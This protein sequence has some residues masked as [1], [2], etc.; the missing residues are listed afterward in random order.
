MEQ[1][2]QRS[3][4]QGRSLAEKIQT[5]LEILED[6]RDYNN[7]VVLLPGSLAAANQY[8]ANNLAVNYR[9]TNRATIVVAAAAQVEAAE[10][11]RAAVGGDDAQL[12]EQRAHA[13]YQASAARVETANNGALIANGQIAGANQQVTDHLAKCAALAARLAAR[14]IDVPGTPPFYLIPPLR[15]QTEVDAERKNN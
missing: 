10:L 14:G 12:A 2:L 6:L 1:Q 11:N 15:V 3:W 4:H 7:E 9:L 8:A 13:V 5:R